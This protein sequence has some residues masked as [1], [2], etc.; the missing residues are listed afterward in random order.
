MGKA[1]EAT[2]TVTEKARDV[3]SSVAHSASEAASNLGSTADDAASAVGSGM[4][5]LAGTIRE[6]APHEGMLG[7]ATS[8]VA[9]TL[10]S[11]GRYLQEEGL[12]GMMEDLTN[13]IRRNPLPAMLIGVGI[14]FL[15]ARTTTRR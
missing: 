3:A 11:G 5:S 10:E 9:N 8:G 6:R 1:K 15:L 4:R 14:G 13:L 2:S 12:S 7:G